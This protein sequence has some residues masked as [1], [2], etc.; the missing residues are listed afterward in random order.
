MYFTNHIKELENKVS[1]I[2]EVNV[3]KEINKEEQNNIQYLLDSYYRL[4]NVDIKRE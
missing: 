1:C 4:S 2:Y 3:G